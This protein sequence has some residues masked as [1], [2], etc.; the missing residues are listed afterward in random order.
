VGLPVV[1]V[2]DDATFVSPTLALFSRPESRFVAHRRYR[3]SRTTA[4]V[5]VPRSIACRDSVCCPAA[6]RT[7]TVSR[8]SSMSVSETFEFSEAWSAT[9]VA[10]VIREM[11]T[12]MPCVGSVW[13]RHAS[14]NGR[15]AAAAG[16]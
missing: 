10:V 12:S 8:V 13:G 2:I 16:A 3:S 11:S 5:P 9:L 15:R 6:V 1:Y 14:A 7:G 4:S